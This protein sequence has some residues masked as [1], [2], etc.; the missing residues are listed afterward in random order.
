M[1]VAG[2]TLNIF[3]LTGISNINIFLI[4]KKN[5]MAITSRIYD[6]FA[7]KIMTYNVKKKHYTNRFIKNQHNIFRF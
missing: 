6:E 7:S 3:L 2:E 1:L 4:K 5:N